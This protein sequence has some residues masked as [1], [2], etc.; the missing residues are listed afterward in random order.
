MMIGIRFRREEKER[1]Q[2]RSGWVKERICWL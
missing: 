1:R 2:K